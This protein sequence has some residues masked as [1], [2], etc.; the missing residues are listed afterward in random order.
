MRSSMKKW[1]EVYSNF[2]EADDRWDVFYVVQKIYQ[3]AI[4]LDDTHRGNIQK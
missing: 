2:W 4:L 1:E 3:Y